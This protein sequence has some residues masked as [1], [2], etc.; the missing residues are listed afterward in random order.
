MLKVLVIHHWD[1]DGLASAALAAEGLAKILG[2]GAREAELQVNFFHPTIGNYSFTSEQ[3]AAIKQAAYDV[4][5]MVD[6]G[7]P[8][9]EIEKIEKRVGKLFV[10]DHHAQTAQI[11]LPGRQDTSYPGCS[12]LVSDF[13]EYPLSVV[14]VLGAVGDLEDRL[15]DQK[16]FYSRVEQVMQEQNFTYDELMRMTK[17][18]D[19][20]YILADE[21]GIAA[22]IKKLRGLIAQPQLAKELILENAELLQN[23]AV[24]QEVL[25]KEFNREIQKVS[26]KILYMALESPYHILSRVTRYKSHQYPD[27]IVVID[28]INQDHAQLYVRRRQIDVDLTALIA[29]A[30]QKGY[31]A[32]G[33]PEVVGVVVPAAHLADFRREVFNFLKNL[34]A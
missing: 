34:S 32:G 16:E 22:L 7:F 1:T 8:I 29:L 11:N 17:L 25:E 21:V 26:E 28:K 20:V 12:L 31:T 5:I 14:G 13:L 10:F 19:T 3:L 15:K 2:D 24:L 4:A 18:I 27:K 33:K 23:E 6:L 30:R 9:E